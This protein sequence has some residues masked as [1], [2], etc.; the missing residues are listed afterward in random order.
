MSRS[1]R[2]P[3]PWL[4]GG[5]SRGQ[6]WDEPHCSGEARPQ[7]EPLIRDHEERVLEQGHLDGETDAERLKQ[8]LLDQLG[9]EPGFATIAVEVATEYRVTLS[10]GTQ[11]EEQ[12]AAVQ[13]LVERALRESP[14][15]AYVTNRIRITPA[16][17]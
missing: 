1:R 16:R 14:R 4:A 3:E 6:A 5:S 9:R 17:E 12:R 13:R 2:N 11:S 10:G 7:D 15:E 8:S